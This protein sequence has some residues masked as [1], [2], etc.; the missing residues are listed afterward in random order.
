MPKHPL[1]LVGIDRTSF[2][3]ARA[4]LT[5]GLLRFVLEQCW[6]AYTGLE[7]HY[8]LLGFIIV[9]PDNLELELFLDAWDTA[10]IQDA[11]QTLNHRLTE[12]ASDLLIRIKDELDLVCSHY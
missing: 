12:P 6:D 5:W 11:I 3:A 10:D 2:G 8:V 1:V 7:E 4:T 9:G